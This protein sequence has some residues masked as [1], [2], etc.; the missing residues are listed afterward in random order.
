MKYN[1]DAWDGRGTLPLLYSRTGTGAINEWLCWVH[2]AS[3]VV[4]WGQQGG[5]QQQSQFAC[6]PKNVGRANETTAQQQAILEAIAK[7]KKQV[8]KKYFLTVAETEKINLKPMLAK[9]FKKRKK[10]VPYPVSVQPKFDGVRCLAYLRGDEVVLQSR[11]GD[12]YPVKHIAEQVRELL[13]FLAQQGY[14]QDLVLDGELYVHGL[15][16]QN[17]IS[18]AKRAQEDSVQLVYCIYDV[19]KLSSQEEPWSSRR[20]MLAALGS[21]ILPPSLSVTQTDQA[22]DEAAVRYYHDEF[23]KLGYEGAIIRL[24]EGLYR[25]GYRSSELL[26]WKE[27]MEEEFLIV[28]WTTGKGKFAQ[29]P[30]FTCT[31]KQGKEFEATP[32]G[33]EAERLAMLHKADALVGKKLTVRFLQWTDDGKPQ[34]PVGVAI[35]EGT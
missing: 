28:G 12:P 25:F 14:P 13:H 31:T 24:D 19:T 23:V 33:T 11:G 22:Y 20:V 26:K 21:M 32:K 8:K 15:S 30:I 34:H 10:P 9:E 29:V 27:F 4:Q 5:A 35:R 3:V 2:D 16:L 17:I 6:T 1:P 7:W 18:L